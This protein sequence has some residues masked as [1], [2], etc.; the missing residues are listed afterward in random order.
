MS[1]PTTTPEPWLVTLWIRLRNRVVSRGYIAFELLMARLTRTPKLRILF[2]PVRGPDKTITRSFRFTPHEIH[3]GEFRPETAAEFDMLVPLLFVDAVRRL[4]ELREHLGHSRLPIPSRAAIDACDDKLAFH[5]SMTAAGLG[6]FL[7]RVDDALAPP[8]MLKGRWGHAGKTVHL[9][10][11][12]SD[13]RALPAGAEPDDYFRQELLPGRYEYCAHILFVDGRIRRALC[14]EHDMAREISVKGALKPL[15]Q[16]IVR[17]RYLPVFARMLAALEFEGLCNIDFKLRDGKPL[18]ME[19][20]PRMGISLCPYFF[21]F[22][23]SLPR[24][25]PSHAQP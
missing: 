8:Y 17:C 11:D 5:R 24:A 21:A 22:V 6:E 9:V 7:P 25:N 23:R 14:I 12:E 20:N 10:L 13:A 1:T 2:S 16:R 19:V 15:R 4:D 18:V 3:F